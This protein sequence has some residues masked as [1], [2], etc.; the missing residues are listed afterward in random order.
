[1]PIDRRIIDATHGG[2]LVAKAPKAA[3]NLIANMAFN[4]Q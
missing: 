2:V 4:S 1:M 3:Q